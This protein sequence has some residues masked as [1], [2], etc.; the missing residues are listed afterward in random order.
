MNIL[1]IISLL[2][3]KHYICDFL[4]QTNYQAVHKFIYGHLGGLIHAFLHGLGTLIVLIF[5]YSIE[6]AGLCALLDFIIHY[7]IDWAKATL[8]RV[9]KPSKRRCFRKDILGIFWLNQFLHQLT[10]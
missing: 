7:H 8:N 9:L 1:I 2:L 3:F 6:T 5:F 4:L 10:Y